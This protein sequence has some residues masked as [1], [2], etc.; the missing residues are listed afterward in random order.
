M[1]ASIHRAAFGFIAAVISVLVFHQAMWALL[2][3]AGLMPPPYPTQG[4]PP[5]GVPLIADLCFWGGLWGAA[6]GLVLPSLPAAPPMWLKGLGLG[7]AAALTGL[8][9]VSAIKGQ[10]LA[11]GWA[12][13]AFVRSFLIN[14][15]WGIGVGLIL[16]FLLRPAR[17]KFA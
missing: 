9:I 5:F 6:F 7:I 8:F 3:L 13:M 16:P 17:A 12:A 10:P 14:G 2:H 4:V 1:P 15:F 11:G